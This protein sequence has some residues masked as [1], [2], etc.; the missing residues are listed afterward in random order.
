MTTA[1]SSTPSSGLALSAVLRRISWPAAA[2]ASSALS[3]SS[4]GT[5][6]ASHDHSRIL[7]HSY[8]TPFYVRPDDRRL[9]RLA[10]HRAEPP[11]RSSSTRV[12]GLDLFPA[13][14]ETP[15]SEYTES[16][17]AWDI[18]YELLDV[19]AMKARFPQ[20]ELP[21][22]TTGLYQERGAIAA[23][24]RGTAAMQSEA[25][26]LAPT[27]ATSHR[28]RESATSATAVSRC[29]RPTRRSCR[30]RVD[31]LRRCVDEPPARRARLVDPADHHARAGDVL[32]AGAPRA[33]RA[34]LDAAVDL[35]GRPV[36][37]RDADL[38]RVDHQDGRGLRGAE[39]TGDDRPFEPDPERLRRLADFVAK[40][41]PDAGPP[42]RSKTCL[43]TL[44]HDRDFLLGAC[45]GTR[46]CWSASVP[47]TVSSSRRRSAGSS[48]A[49]G[50]RL[51]VGRHRRVPAR[52]AR[53]R[54]GRARALAI[55]ALLMPGKCRAGTRRDATGRCRARRRARRASTCGARRG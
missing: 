30:R 2:P 26:R 9:Q 18:G 47:A 3:S 51:D 44:T 36:L 48:P 20:F 7:R 10:D 27:S 12:G 6:A 23:A 33:I 32:P 41:I 34:G 21:D 54:R 29:T 8:H 14:T 38:S 19:A 39:V 40:T 50:R 22:G 25:R 49:R 1:K 16:L 4:S 15:Y 43:Y 11:A 28:S 42:V 53:H 55:P 13:D 5:S 24:A 37:L 46:R 31:R 45:Q 52:P 35:D 17:D